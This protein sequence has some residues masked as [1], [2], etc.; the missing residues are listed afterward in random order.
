M[1]FGGDE[2]VRGEARWHGVCL[3]LAELARRGLLLG[4]TVERAVSW[5]F[6]VILSE[7]CTLLIHRP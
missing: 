1:G 3:A 2:T 7:A 4:D 6:K 5:L